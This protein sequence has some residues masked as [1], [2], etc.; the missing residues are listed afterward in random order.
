MIWDLA[1]YKQTQV[2]SDA[3]SNWGQITCI[4]WIPLENGVTVHGLLCFG[5]GRGRVV[6]YR[7]QRR[8][9][10]VTYTYQSWYAD[11]WYFYRTSYLKVLTGNYS[12]WEIALKLSLSTPSTIGSLQ[13]VIR[14]KSR[15][16]DSR[17]KVRKYRIP[18]FENEP[19]WGLSELSPLWTVEQIEGVPRSAHF[20]NRGEEVIVYTLESGEV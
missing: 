5:T 13:Q 18:D 15:C 6:I 1:N 9:V 7:R 11:T 10:G 16:F 4:L 17:K 12:A 3:A 2:L 14:E 19:T 20:V 8:R